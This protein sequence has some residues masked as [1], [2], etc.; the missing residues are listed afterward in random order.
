MKTQKNN[1]V[2]AEAENI[3]NES[4]KGGLMEQE[5]NDLF[6]RC[7]AIRTTLLEKVE[8]GSCRSC[9]FCVP[10][11]SEKREELEATRPGYKV[12]RISDLP[13]FYCFLEGI[14]H[15]YTKEALEE[16]A[17]PIRFDLYGTTTRTE[18]C[19]AYEPGTVLGSLTDNE[20]EEAQ[21][22]KYAF[23]NGMQHISHLYGELNQLLDGTL[24]ANLKA[25]LDKWDKGDYSL[26]DD[27]IPGDDIPF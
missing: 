17:F 26:E 18:A 5:T 13:D 24:Q 9:L 11:D 21:R 15:W 10:F 20:L 19:L 25:A 2:L 3:L 1:D 4:K 16:T 12:N 7:Q 14:N 27:E 6:S 23:L 22:A 8:Q